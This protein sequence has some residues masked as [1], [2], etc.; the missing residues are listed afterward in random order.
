MAYEKNCRNSDQV[1]ASVGLHCNNLIIM[2]GQENVKKKKK[3][4]VVALR[5]TH[6]K[7]VT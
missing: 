3:G 2:Q 5:K 4:N 7:S 6:P 1:C